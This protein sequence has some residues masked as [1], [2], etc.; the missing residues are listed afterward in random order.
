MARIFFFFDKSQ[1][2]VKQNQKK[3]EL[4]FEKLLKTALLMNRLFFPFFL[5]SMKSLQ[6]SGGYKCINLIT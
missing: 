5:A 6:A 4:L 1:N 3:R 2:L